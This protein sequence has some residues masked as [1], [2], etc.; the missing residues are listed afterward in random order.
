[1]VSPF[2]FLVTLF[3]V[4]HHLA[5]VVLPEVEH[6]SLSPLSL[7]KHGPITPRSQ[8]DPWGT[9]KT[10]AMD[11]CGLA[12]DQILWLI[13][14]RTDALFRQR[15]KKWSLIPHIQR[16][17]IALTVTPP[18]SL[19]SLLPPRYAMHSIVSIFFLSLNICILIPSHLLDLSNCLSI[20]CDDALLTGSWTSCLELQG[21][22][23]C[24]I[25]LYIMYHYR[26][27]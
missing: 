22:F 2:S 23:I 19:A 12:W 7:K 8:T 10:Y 16:S 11:L 24:L 5:K 3:S 4:F 26:T 14:Q 18:A 25:F 27:F 21:S 13:N 1:M 15:C 6:E 17:S 20:F 9:Q